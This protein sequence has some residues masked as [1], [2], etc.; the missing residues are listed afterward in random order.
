MNKT[1]VV[2]HQTINESTL[3]RLLNEALKK[4]CDRAKPL[5]SDPLMV[6]YSERD[7]D[8]MISRS[9]HYI[10]SVHRYR[11]LWIIP[12]KRYNQIFAISNVHH[13][14]GYPK[15]SCLLSNPSI[16][17]MVEEELETFSAKTGVAVD[18][19]IESQEG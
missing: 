14:A 17:G 13:G 12:R 7:P 15:V 16:L 1:K 19:E 3:H 11:W 6:G 4:I 5:F 8:L 2:K 9:F 10:V 18:L